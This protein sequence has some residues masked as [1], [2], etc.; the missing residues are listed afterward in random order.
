MPKEMKARLMK[1][2][3]KKGLK[4]KDLDNF[5]F[6]VMKNAEKRKKRTKRKGPTFE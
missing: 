6:V 3:R 5:V 1:E 4:G 2:G